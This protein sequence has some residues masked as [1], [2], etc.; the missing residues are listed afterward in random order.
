MYSHDLF[1]GEKTKIIMSKQTGDI[2]GYARQKSIFDEC[3]E[4]APIKLTEDK[5]QLNIF[6]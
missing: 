1:E 6:Q 3:P 4:A 2:L 5:N